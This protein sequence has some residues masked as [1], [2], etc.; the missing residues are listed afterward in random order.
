[1]LRL[2]LKRQRLL[3]RSFRS[4]HRLRAVADRTQQIGSDDIL[5]FAC[6]RNEA[7]RLPWFLSHHRALGVQ[8][9]LFVDNASDD[10]SR[11]FLAGE[12]D[13]SVWTTRASY[14]AS[15]FGLDWVNWLLMHYGHGHWCLTLDADEAFIYPQHDTLP[16]RALTE[17]LDAEGTRAFGALMLDMYPKGPLDAAPYR[18]GDDPFATL[19][20]FDAGNYTVLHKPL[21][22][23]QWVQGGARARLFF[24]DAPR[25]APTLNKIPLVKWH[26]RFA[27]VNSTHSLL[28]RQLNQ[29]HDAAG[30][31]LASGVLLHSKFLPTI[32]AKSREEKTRREHFG[33]AEAFDAYYDGLIANP[34]LWHEAACEY[35]GWRQ[36]VALGLMH[37]GNA[38]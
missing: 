13:C 19:R 6:V 14:K 36:L 10:G 32:I 12:P 27:Y 33:E 25:R 38:R 24:A 30:L 23:C 34:D 31:P 4:R 1:M 2:R 21:L 15:R 28:P 7:V 35:A 5:A 17:R 9:F 16:L 26:R 22:R 3:W 37:E 29:M 8:H 11:D 20:W 18:M